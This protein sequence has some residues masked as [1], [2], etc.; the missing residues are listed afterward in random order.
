MLFRSVAHDVPTEMLDM[1]ADGLADLHAEFRVEAF[2]E[3]EQLPDGAWA[4]AADYRLTGTA[5]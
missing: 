2:T 4:V 5:R 1:A 3:F